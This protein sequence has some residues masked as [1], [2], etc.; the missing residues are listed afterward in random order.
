MKAEDSPPH[1]YL[2]NYQGFSELS[3]ER[4]NTIR[5]ARHDF[6]SCYSSFIHE[7]GGTR[8]HQLNERQ[9]ET[10]LYQR[11]VRGK[12]TKYVHMEI[13]SSHGKFFCSQ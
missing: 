7:H 3:Y 10:I 2:I 4:G 11:A 5:C 12:Q 9:E 1:N 13:K 6:F 8:Q